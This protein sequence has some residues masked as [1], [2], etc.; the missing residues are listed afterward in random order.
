MSQIMA[1]HRQHVK[2][3]MLVTCELNGDMFL[4]KQDVRALFGKLVQETYH[5][6]KNDAKN[7]CMW[8]QQ[9]INSL[10]YYQEI[11]VEVDGGLTKQNMLFTLGIQRPWQREMIIEHGHQGS[12]AI[13]TT[14]ETNERKVR[15]Y[16]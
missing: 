15:H 12:V 7:V 10:F 2:N 9:N 13:D 5:L 1:K 14:Y 6:H 3:I 8:V 4:A 16:V 11:G